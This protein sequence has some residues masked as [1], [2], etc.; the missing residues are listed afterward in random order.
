MS[1]IGVGIDIVDL[2]WFRTLYHLD[3]QDVL[4]RVF[5]FLELHEAR[6][7]GDPIKRLAGRYAAKEAAL[8]V[9]GGLQQGRALTDL[10]IRSTAQQP[11]LFL[12]GEAAI[13]ADALSIKGWHVSVTHTES[14]AAAVVIA[15]A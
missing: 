4:S 10:E 6:A 12:S 13:R 1:L 11:V 7:A 5:T 14:A 3:D 2:N 8:K 15:S 9:L